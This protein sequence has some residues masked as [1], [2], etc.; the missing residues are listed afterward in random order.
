MIQS[1][2]TPSSL[3][4]ITFVLGLSLSFIFPWHVTTY[5]EDQMVTLVGV[6]LLLTSLT[7]NILAY[8]AFK[9]A[10]T[11]YEPFAKP[12]TLLTKG[13]FAWSRNPVYL[14][15]VLSQFGLA[16]VFD[17]FWL[18]IGAIVLWIVL[19]ILIVRQEE[20]VLRNTFYEE[21]KTYKSKTRR[22]F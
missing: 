8:R 19:D 5:I 16:F 1:K 10:T 22:W 21:Y 7:L 4:L 20:V 12:K 18:I 17:T 14:A 3:F 13:V 15:L 11:S 9:N 6:L 2:L